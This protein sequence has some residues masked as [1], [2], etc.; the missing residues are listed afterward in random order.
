MIDYRE[1]YD[2]YINYESDC[3]SMRVKKS[4]QGSKAL[5]NLLKSDLTEVFKLD[6]YFEG[7]FQFKSQCGTKVI[8]VCFKCTAGVDLLEFMTIQDILNVEGRSFLDIQLHERK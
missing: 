7:L 5:N 4:L 2:K 1:E 8:G 6:G 3:F